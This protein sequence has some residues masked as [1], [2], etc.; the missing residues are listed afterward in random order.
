M[1]SRVL[2]AVLTFLL[3]LAAGAPAAS[4][5]PVHP[6]DKIEI[7]LSDGRMFLC[8]LNSVARKDGALYGISAGHCLAPVGSAKPVRIYS[9]DG[10]LIASD[11]RDSGYVYELGG[12]SVGTGGIT[13]DGFKDQSWFRLDRHVAAAGSTRGGNLTLGLDRGMDNGLTQFARSINPDRAIGG[14]LPVSAVR[15]GQIVCKDGARTSRTCGPVVS[16]NPHT[17]EIVALLLSAEGDSGAPAWV[18]GRDGRAY[19][20]GVVSGGV[21]P[22]EVIDASLPLP[23]GLR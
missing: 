2:A 18:T 5:A 3:A 1:K 9:S 6:G 20:V 19:I 10:E 15:V 4:A 23:A 22:L 21:G 16:T 17:G 13:P 12:V 8:T 7:H 11:L 14:R